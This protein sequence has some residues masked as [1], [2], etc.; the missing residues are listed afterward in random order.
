[1]FSC[2]PAISIV[3]KMVW[4]VATYALVNSVFYTFLNVSNTVYM[5]RAFP[6]NE[7]YVVLNSSG[8]IVSMIFVAAFNIA[9]PAL[10]DKY[11]NSPSG[12][13]FLMAC[14]AIPFAIIGLMRFVFIKETNDIDVKAADGM[15]KR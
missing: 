12:W 10:I 8:A 2:P 9:S 14:I 4:V 11:G 3:A 7:Q 13:S 1:M 5:C 15:T 6:Y